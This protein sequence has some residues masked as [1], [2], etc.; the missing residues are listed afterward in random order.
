MTLRQNA[1]SVSVV[2][3]IELTRR[4]G[5]RYNPERAAP[6]ATGLAV[7]RFHVN[8]DGMAAFSA[9]GGYF[10]F[11]SVIS[12]T[13]ISIKPNVNNAVKASQVTI[14]EPP[15][16]RGTTTPPALHIITHCARCFGGC[17]ARSRAP[18]PVLLCL[19]PLVL[20]PL[21]RVG[22]DG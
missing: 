16:S 10:F 15:I 20:L 18:R 7:P 5:A 6:A 8:R 21:P 13:A 19:F 4:R 11:R 3:V 9:G 12:I 1:F 17:S 2:V 22:A 14:I